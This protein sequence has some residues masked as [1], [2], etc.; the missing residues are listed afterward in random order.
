MVSYRTS[1]SRLL[2]PSD[3]SQS[4]MALSKR[5]GHVR[6][7]VDLSQLKKRTKRAPKSRA[8]KF[9]M[10]KPC[11]AHDGLLYVK[12]S[13]GRNEMESDRERIIRQMKN[14]EQEV[15]RL[16]KM[17]KDVNKMKK[18]LAI[19]RRRSMPVPSPVSISLD[20]NM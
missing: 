10:S 19:L 15:E 8:K 1:C 16:R 11:F 5:T 4:D 14:L 3:S 9:D 13:I 6:N 20:T 7:N 18:T 12:L 2:G 17:E